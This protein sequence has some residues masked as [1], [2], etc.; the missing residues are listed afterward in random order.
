MTL[1]EIMLCVGLANLLLCTVIRLSCRVCRCLLLAECLTDLDTSLRWWGLRDN[2]ACRFRSV[3]RWS[4]YDTVHTHSRS[5]KCCGRY[6]GRLEEWRKKRLNSPPALV[7]KQSK[8]FPCIYFAAGKTTEA[9]CG[10]YK[11]RLY[12]AGFRVSVYSHQGTG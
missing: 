9:R 7:N 8:L 6:T 4:G 3:G 10:A 12:N 2:Q 1:T 11:E 5:H